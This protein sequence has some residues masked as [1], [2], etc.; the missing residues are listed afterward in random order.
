MSRLALRWMPRLGTPRAGNCLPLLG[1]MVGGAVG[2]RIFYCLVWAQKRLR[3]ACSKFRRYPTTVNLIAFK[4]SRTD[5][6]RIERC[7]RTSWKSFVSNITSSISNRELWHKVKKAFGTPTSN[8]ISALCVNGQTTTSSLKGIANTIASTLANTS[9]SKNYNREFINHKMKPDKKKLNFNS[10]SDYSYN[11]NFT[12]QEFQDC[13]SKVHKSSPDPDNISYIMLL[14]LTESQT[15]L[16]YLFNRI[17][18][19]QCFP[20]SCQE[21]IIIPIPKP[22]KDATNPSNCRPIVLT[23]CLCKILEKMINRK[24]MHFLET[25]NLL[26]AFQ[27]GFR[28]GRSTLDNILAL[29]TDIRLAFMQRKHLVA[30][31]LTLRRRTTVPG[32]K[33]ASQGFIIYLCWIPSRVVIPGNEQADNAAKST[34]FS[35]NGTVPIGD[36]KK[37]IKLLLYTKWQDQWNVEAGNKLHADKPTVETWPPLKNRKPDIVLTRLRVGHARF[38]QRHLLLGEPVPVCSQRNCT[39]SVHHILSECSN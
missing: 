27:S 34:T 22:G 9:N 16:L 12:F 19:E 6:R 21:A 13:L 2:S 14:H 11:C 31:I 32:E 23:S 30:I 25:K 33:L 28:K 4:R 8:R 1:S 3:K 26:S 7:S 24:L 37:H 17:W 36:L 39:M 35:I 20:S 5:F 15:N 38:T 29:E 10:R 18:N